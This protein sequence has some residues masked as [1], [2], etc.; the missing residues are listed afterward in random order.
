MMADF[1]ANGE[2]VLPCKHCD[3]EAPACLCCFAQIAVKDDL[4]ELCFDLGGDA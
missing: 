1:G 4:C 3:Y 2:T